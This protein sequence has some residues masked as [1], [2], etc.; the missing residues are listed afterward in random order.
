[1]GSLSE[2]TVRIVHELGGL[3]CR[4][5]RLKEKGLTFCRRCY[6]LLPRPLQKALCK[7]LADGYVEAYAA[8]VKYIDE[9]RSTMECDDERDDRQPGD[10]DTRG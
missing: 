8:A 3:Q 2:D 4:C 9:E 5:G 10:E 7:L 6:F 1:V